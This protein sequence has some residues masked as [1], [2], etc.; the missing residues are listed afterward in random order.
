MQA[1]GLA[2]EVIKQNKGNYPLIKEDNITY[3][4]V[5]DDA[6][7]CGDIWDVWLKSRVINLSQAV[8]E[9][10]IKVLQ[11]RSGNPSFGIIR[12][13]DGETIIWMNSC[14]AYDR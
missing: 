5:W 6:Q 9:W 13:T 1:I 14:S 12:A 4:K 7:H 8:V 10:R 3:L 2:S 11:V